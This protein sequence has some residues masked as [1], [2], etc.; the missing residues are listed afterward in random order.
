ML[1]LLADNV[2]G[3]ELVEAGE[4]DLEDLAL[5]CIELRQPARLCDARDDPA[6]L[7]LDT[8]HCGFGREAGASELDL[9]P[10]RADRDRVC[11]DVVPAECIRLVEHRGEVAL[12][13]QQDR[14]FDVVQALFGF[15]DAARVVLPCCAPQLR[16]E[17]RD[18]PGM[19]SRT[20]IARHGLAVVTDRDGAQRL[21]ARR[22]VQLPV[23]LKLPDQ[24]TREAR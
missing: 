17:L 13:E 15:R 18:R 20:Q 9:D 23:R 10:I 11:A 5:R 8:N 3:R 16:E 21:G 7:E 2:D 4:R 14:F 24:E 6:R 1:D 22:A 12:R 19:K